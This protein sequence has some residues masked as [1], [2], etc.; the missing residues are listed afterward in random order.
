MYKKLLVPLDGSKLSE[1]ALEH[2]RAIASGCNVPEVVLLRVIEPVPR[3]AYVGAGEDVIRN[4]QERNKVVIQ[5]YLSKLADD[6][7]KEGIAAQA[8]VLSG[9]PAN[10]ILDYVNKSQPDLVIMS[11]HGRSGPSRWVLGSVAEKVVLHCPISVLI[12]T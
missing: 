10:E 8:V 11:T 9:N 2:A 7:K 1:F 12:V 6:L 4:A 5:E 3:E